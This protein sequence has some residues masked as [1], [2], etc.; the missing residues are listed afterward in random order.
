MP[1]IRD[2]KLERSAESPNAPIDLTR[3]SASMMGAITH[4]LLG[5]TLHGFKSNFGQAG[6]GACLSIAVNNGHQN[7]HRIE[8]VVTST[9][10]ALLRRGAITIISRTSEGRSNNEELTYALTDQMRTLLIDRLSVQLEVAK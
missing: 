10:E 6:D 2:C 8:G 4:M 1:M 3:F 9:V 5:A 7:G